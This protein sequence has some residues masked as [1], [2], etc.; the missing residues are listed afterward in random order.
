MSGYAIGD[1][2]LSSHYEGESVLVHLEDKRCFRLNAT[3]AEIWRGLEAGLG[4]SEIVDRLCARYE[5][6]REEAARAVRD[7]LADLDDKGLVHRAGD[8]E[9]AGE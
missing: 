9:R 3:G 2:V 4:E 8:A 6:G 5:V 7:T 1:D